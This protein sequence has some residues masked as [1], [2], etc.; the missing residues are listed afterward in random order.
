MFWQLNWDKL[1]VEILS[2]KKSDNI[3]NNN[4]DKKQ[5]KGSHM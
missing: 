4:N 1:H 3:D 2:I 5:W